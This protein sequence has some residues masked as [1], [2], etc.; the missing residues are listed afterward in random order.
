[1]PDDQHPADGIVDSLRNDIQGIFNGSNFVNAIRDAWD[2][3]M[4]TQPS[5]P[6]PDKS[7]PLPDAW[8]A[9]N[10]KAIAQQ[11]AQSALTPAS[12]AKIRAKAGR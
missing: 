1:M 9:A 10:Q 2:R 5:S 12:A 11:Q 6:A 8:Q 4:G 3:H 7:A